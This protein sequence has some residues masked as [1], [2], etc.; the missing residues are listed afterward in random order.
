MSETLVLLLALGGLLLVPIALLMFAF[1]APWVRRKGPG[2]AKPWL[3][4]GLSLLGVVV[5]NAYALNLHQPDPWGHMAVYFLVPWI[6]ALGAL[7]GH[8]LGLALFRVRDQARRAPPRVASP[9]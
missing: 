8:G 5:C 7:L 6:S 9:H 2:L 3:L 1:A 4:T